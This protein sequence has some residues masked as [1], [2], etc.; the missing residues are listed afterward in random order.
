M[1]INRIR[2]LTPHPVVLNT[3]QGDATIIAPH[4]STLRIVKG[5]EPYGHMS[6]AEVG[7]V[8]LLKWSPPSGEAIHELNCTL[9]KHLYDNVDAVIVPAMLLEFIYQAHWP[10]VFAPDTSSGGCRRDPSGKVL[11]VYRLV[12]RG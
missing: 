8:P 2:N 11:E 6:I 1:V 4:G 9:V 3:T 10:Q 5:M 12:T 7:V